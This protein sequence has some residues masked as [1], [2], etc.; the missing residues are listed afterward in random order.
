MFTLTQ[1]KHVPTPMNLEI[2]PVF[3]D[4]TMHLN[5]N[6][7]FVKDEQSRLLYANQALLELFPPEKRDK[8]IGQTNADSFTTSEASVFLEEDQRA[9]R[10][11]K[12]DIVEE[13]TDYKMQRRTF[14]TKKMT[15]RASSGKLLLLGFGTEITDLARR[16]RDLVQSNA[17]LENFAALA[18]HD[19]RTPLAS[20]SG[21]LSL[22]L[23]DKKNILTPAATK[24]VAMMQDSL[25][26]L[27]EQ[28][29]SILG[30]YKASHAQKVEFSSTDLNILL[31]EA[32][33]NMGSMISLNKATILSN[34]LPTLAV[35]P[36][37]FRHLIMNFF[38]NSIKYRSPKDPVIILRYTKENGEHVFSVED[39]G[40]GINP[41]EAKKLFQLY[42]QGGKE[43]SGGVGIG[44]ALCRSIIE[45]HGGRV[46]ID[47]DYKHGCRIRFTVQPS[48]LN[49]DGDSLH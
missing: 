5:P 16:E 29:N 33:F 36:N 3:F 26:N 4:V 28:I 25:M 12:S 43:N 13:I 8:I 7:I 15:F 31:E 21:Y 32:K 2:D 17:M 6:I 30:A 47:H 1:H 24:Y 45:M 42:K 44:L 11:G 20:F 34:R 46:W 41:E 37:L 18:A 23:F 9:F 35:D 40:I 14:M 48:P 22:I 27:S 10:E 39:N 49:T 38:E 19:L